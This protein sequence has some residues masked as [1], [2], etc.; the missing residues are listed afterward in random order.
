VRKAK[1]SVQSKRPALL[2]P[3][4]AE[5]LKFKKDFQAKNGYFPRPFE[6]GAWKELRHKKPFG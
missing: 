4:P 2:E 6:I 3:T 1:K 5:L